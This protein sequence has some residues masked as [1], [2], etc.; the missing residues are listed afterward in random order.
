LPRPRRHQHP[1]QGDTLATGL[2]AIRQAGGTIVDGKR[3]IKWPGEAAV[4]ISTV[5]IHKGPITGPYRLDG[6]E[7]ERITAFLF[8]AGGDDDPARLAANAGKSFI[9]SYVLGMGFTFDDTDRK[10]AASP[11]AE[12]H[13]LIEKNPR[14][15]ERIFRYIGGEEVN[16]SPTQSHHRYVISFEDF[17]LERADLGA[18]WQA[19][20]AG[21]RQAWL[22]AG[23]VPW[24]IPIRSP[25]I[26]RIC[27][28]SSGSGEADQ[29]RR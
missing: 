18:T 9:G 21:Q 15:A 14:N 20:S 29:R 28:R 5:H 26:D 13:R 19:A 23:V 25:P 17:P 12:M 24:M 1:G 10:G 27:W 3:R 7:V 22:R 4:V 8:H 2:R 6:R 11:L 16:T